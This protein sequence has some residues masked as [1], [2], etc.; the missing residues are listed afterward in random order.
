MDAMAEGGV[1]GDGGSGGGLGVANGE[2]GA[3]RRYMCRD[4]GGGAKAIAKSRCRLE[5][6]SSLIK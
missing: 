5:S 1:G 3:G 4:E 6:I 2:D